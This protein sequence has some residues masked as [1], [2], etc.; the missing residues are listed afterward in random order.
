MIFNTRHATCILPNEDKPCLYVYNV[1]HY[2]FL[3]DEESYTLVSTHTVQGGSR[4]RLLTN[5]QSTF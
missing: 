1:L 2:I 4:L 3:A 5:Q